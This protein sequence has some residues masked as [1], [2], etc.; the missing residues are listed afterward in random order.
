MEWPVVSCRS[1]DSYAAGK[2]SD[3]VAKLAAVKDESTFVAFLKALEDDRRN[4]SDEWECS[5]IE[6]FLEAATRWH[7]DYKNSLNGYKM[8]ENA[9]RRAAEIIYCGKIYE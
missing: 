5:T 7:E 4:S 6:S 2:M 9:W 8:P 1:S 3:L